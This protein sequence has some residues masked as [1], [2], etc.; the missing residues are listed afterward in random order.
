MSGLQFWKSCFK[1]EGRR[2]REEGRGKKEEGRRKR[3]EGRGRIFL[4]SPSPSRP[5]QNTSGTITVIRF[6][7]RNASL[8][9]LM[10]TYIPRYKPI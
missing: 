2:K 5:I 3:E 10:R 8:Q 1:E 7:V 6:V 4:T 9:S